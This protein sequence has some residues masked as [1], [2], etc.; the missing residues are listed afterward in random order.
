MKLRNLITNALIVGI[1]LSVIIFLAGCTVKFK[2]TD[3]DYEG[4]ITKV[5]E[6]DGLEF[7][8]IFDS[9]DEK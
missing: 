8:K 5:Y 6:F 9:D 7:A 2:G 1:Y 4:T 3:V